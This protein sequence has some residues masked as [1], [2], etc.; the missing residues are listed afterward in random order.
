M[1]MRRKRLPGR[2][3]TVCFRRSALFGVKRMKHS[4][5]EWMKIRLERSRWRRRRGAL[6]LMLRNPSRSLLKVTRST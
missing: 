5:N 1:K 2:R 4:V 6:P 3:T